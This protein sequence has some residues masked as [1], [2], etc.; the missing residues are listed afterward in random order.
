MKVV[1]SGLYMRYSKM[2]YI[3]FYPRFNRFTMKCFM[4][5]ALQFWG[6]S[7]D[8]CI[9]DNTN[10]AIHYGTGANAVMV[11]EMIA[12]A[13]NYGFEWKAHEIKH[14][15]RKAGTER[16][17]WTVETNFF[18]GRMFASLE[19]L[20]KQALEWATMRYAK[21]PQSKTGLIPCEAFEYEKPFLN[22]LKE[23]IT[24]VYKPH[25]RKLDDYGYVSFEANYYWVPEY[26]GKKERISEVDVIGYAASL[27]I[28][29]KRVRLAI[30]QL[31]AFGIRNQRFAPDGVSPKHKPRNRK[32]K[33]KEEEIA[34][35]DMGETEIRYLDFVL[36]KD[37]CIH[38][39][40]QYIRQL[41]CFSRK[42][43]PVLRQKTLQRALRYKVNN[44]DA[45]NR[46]ASTLVRNRE[47]E[48]PEPSAPHTYM[49]REAYRNGQFNDEPGFEHLSNLLNEGDN[50]N[51]ICTQ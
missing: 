8:V 37:S 14:S 22:K 44:M 20:N 43:A 41:Y 6:Y 15:N 9:I 38:N 21:R 33:S 7:A 4:E 11:T 16:N 51:E 24:P 27:A 12:F 32:V 10:L 45:L 39:K 36:S 3:K 50:D 17:F 19:D 42:I 18:P 23:Y 49:E 1:C 5:E 26:N 46:I 48:I 31:P 28:F 30:Y 29:Y 40:H 25:R 47:E 2:R 13:R 34:L 35:R